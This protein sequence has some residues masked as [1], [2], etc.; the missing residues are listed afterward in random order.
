MNA[1]PLSWKKAILDALLWLAFGLLVSCLFLLSPASR[2]VEHL[3]DQLAL[4]LI[5]LVW[6]CLVVVSGW[7]RRS[8]KVPVVFIVMALLVGYPCLLILLLAL[9]GVWPAK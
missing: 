9:N 4:T 8:W 3:G 1:K 7:A 5:L 2:T 6:L